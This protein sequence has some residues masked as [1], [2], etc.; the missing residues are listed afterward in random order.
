MIFLQLNIS[1]SYIGLKA[2]FRPFLYVIVVIVADVTLYLLK[3]LDA[4][5]II[6]CITLVC[7]NELGK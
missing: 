6:Q 1:F 7:S 3:L 2:T 4:L 5:K